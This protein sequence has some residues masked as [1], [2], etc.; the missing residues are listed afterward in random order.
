MENTFDPQ[1]KYTW[2]PTD[3]ISLTGE[4][5]GALTTIIQSLN[6]TEL[7]QMFSAF[8]ILGNVLGDVVK[9]NVESGLFKE[10]EEIKT[11][12]GADLT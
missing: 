9:E 6:Q 10:K 12:D 5:F 1:K 8:K 3:K 11:Y 2:E 4:Q 7:A